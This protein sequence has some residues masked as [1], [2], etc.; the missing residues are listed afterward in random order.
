MRVLIFGDSIAQGFW[1]LDGGW[2][3]RIRRSYDAR[4]IED[5]SRN[6]PMVFNVGISGDTSTSLCKRF[7]SETL[8]RKWLDEEFAVVITVGVNDACIEAGKLW[9]TPDE[10]RQ[11]ITKLVEMAQELSSKVLFVGL[12]PC[13]EAK[14]TPVAWGDY[15]YRNEVIRRLDGILRDLCDQ[16]NLPFVPVFEAFAGKEKELLPDGLH[17]N[18]KGHELIADLV[19]P[20]LKNL[21]N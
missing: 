3:A 4:Q 1:D 21:L 15:T 6:E 18:N 17:P 13:D 19:Q 16:Y 10:Y 9:T 7:R 2:A 11:N 5:M 20:E 8:A 12:T 14:T